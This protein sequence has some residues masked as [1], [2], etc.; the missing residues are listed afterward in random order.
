MS[1]PIESKPWCRDRDYGGYCDRGCAR[2]LELL[3][4]RRDLTPDQL[5]RFAQRNLAG[6]GGCADLPNLQADTDAILRS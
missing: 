1:G 4:Q 2:R 3:N 6:A 5:K